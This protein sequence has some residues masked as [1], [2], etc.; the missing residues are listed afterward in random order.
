MRWKL[1]HPASFLFLLALKL[2]QALSAFRGGLGMESTNTAMNGARAGFT[3]AFL[4]A[5]WKAVHNKR[6]A[7]SPEAKLSD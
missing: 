4:R 7:Q 5:A 6:N 3:L 2:F 1:I